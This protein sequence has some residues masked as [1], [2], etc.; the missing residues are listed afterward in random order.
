M[1]LVMVSV[2]LVT[3]LRLLCSV[4]F[5]EMS[6]TVSSCRRH[7]TPTVDAAISE[8]DFHWRRPGVRSPE[9]TSSVGESP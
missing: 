3:L 4:L 8:V 7:P 2:L 9:N 5:L 1:L 6:V